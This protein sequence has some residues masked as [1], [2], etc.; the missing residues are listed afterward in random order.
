MTVVFRAVVCARS[1]LHTRTLR[2]NDDDDDDDDDGDDDGD[3]NG[4]GG[5]ETCCRLAGR[6]RRASARTHASGG[7]TGGA[8]GRCDASLRQKRA[9]DGVRASGSILSAALER[10]RQRVRVDYRQSTAAAAAAAATTTMRG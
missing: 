5:R 7:E 9:K 1:R 6:E 2:D 4:G 10:R 8:C 3:N